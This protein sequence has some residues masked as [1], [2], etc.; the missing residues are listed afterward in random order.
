MTFR[1]SFPFRTTLHVSH[2]PGLV[3]ESF[4]PLRVPIVLCRR[5]AHAHLWEMLQ[6]SGGDGHIAALTPVRSHAVTRFCT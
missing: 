4:E 5:Q 2:D 3:L 6:E 1:A